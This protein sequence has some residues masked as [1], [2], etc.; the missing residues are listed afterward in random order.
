M[1][2]ELD[3]YARADR[4]AVS[5]WKNEMSAMTWL[6][7]L[8]FDGLEAASQVRTPSLFVQRDACVLPQNAKSVFDRLPGQ[9][10]MIW[11]DGAQTDFYDRKPFVEK[12]VAGAHEHCAR[13][14]NA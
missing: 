1:F 11:T 3:Y 4:G 6:Y 10:Q 8:T 12:A 5:A 9:K 14:L 13:T 7:W 2:F